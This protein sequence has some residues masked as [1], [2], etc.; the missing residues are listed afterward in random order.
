VCGPP[1]TQRAVSH[2][3]TH[4]K[5][6]MFIH[7]LTHS[8]T[9]KLIK[10]SFQYEGDLF[11]NHVDMKHNTFDD[12]LDRIMNSRVVKDKKTVGRVLRAN[13]V[14]CKYT[15]RFETD[16]NEVVCTHALFDGRVVNLLEPSSWSPF[17]RYHSPLDKRI[18]ELIQRVHHLETPYADDIDD[19]TPVFGVSTEDKEILQNIRNQYPTCEILPGLNDVHRQK[20]ARKIQKEMPSDVN[21]HILIAG[22]SVPVEQLFRYQLVRHHTSIGYILE[23]TTRLKDVWSGEFY[24]LPMGKNT[25]IIILSGRGVKSFKELLFDSLKLNHETIIIL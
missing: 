12:I 6:I 24:P 8:L 4:H 18:L 16:E 23:N 21:A 3:T 10:M 14:D 19:Y 17:I 20:I 15:V 5:P 2:H 7:S 11:V 13:Y 25:I 1:V 22:T 9:H